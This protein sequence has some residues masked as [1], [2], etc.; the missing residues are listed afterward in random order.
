MSELLVF[1]ILFA[2]HAAAISFVFAMLFIY[3][4]RRWWLRAITVV[5]G[6]AALAL[7]L[8]LATDTLGYPDPWPA[9]GRY[10]VLGWDVDETGGALF[11]FVMPP[12]ATAPHHL[13]LP[14]DLGLALKLQKAQEQIG[15]Y[16]QITV[17]IFDETAEDGPGYALTIERV[18]PDDEEDDVQEDDHAGETV[19]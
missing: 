17:D 5:F 7:P 10:D 4:F 1:I 11:L 16:K 2:L 19:R 18:F 3:D 8:K 14:F 13:R 6:L 15:I 9:S 12:D